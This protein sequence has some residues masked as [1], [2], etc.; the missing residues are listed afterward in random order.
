VDGMQKALRVVKDQLFH[1]FRV[2][3]GGGARKAE[4]E[5]HLQRNE[6]VHHPSGRTKGRVLDKNQVI[7]SSLHTST[8]ASM[9]SKNLG[10]SSSSPLNWSGHHVASAWNITVIMNEKDY[11]HHTYFQK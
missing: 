7:K 8:S 10:G 1:H 2:E 4:Q 3:S 5:V 9:L 6:G 11:K